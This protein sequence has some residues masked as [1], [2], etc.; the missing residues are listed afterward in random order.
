MARPIPIVYPRDSSFTEDYPNLASID[1]VEILHELTVVP[2]VYKLNE[3]YFPPQ[4][5]KQ[6][7]LT[8]R[9]SLLY[10]LPFEGRDPNDF[11]YDSENIYP[12]IAAQSSSLMLRA[13]EDAEQ[14]GR[15]LRHMYKMRLA[16]T[17]KIFQTD[18]HEVAAEARALNSQGRNVP[19][20]RVPLSVV[21]NIRGF[22]EGKKK[23][24][25]SKKLKKH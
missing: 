2:E 7:R 1:A 24:S 23:K 3:L 22:M 21:E 5:D 10:K 17:N 6:R 14:R 8:E 9:L 12:Y 16:N 15:F 18:V 25:K 4:T 13:V 19:L 20:G 11:I